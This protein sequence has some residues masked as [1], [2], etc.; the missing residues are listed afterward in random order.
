MLDEEWEKE[1]GG[2]T[3]KNAWSKLMFLKW[4][5]A[6][7]IVPLSSSPQ[8]FDK[9]VKD[10]CLRKCVYILGVIKENYVSTNLLVPVATAGTPEMKAQKG[11]RKRA[12]GKNYK[13]IKRKFTMMWLWEWHYDFLAPIPTRTW[14]RRSEVQAYLYAFKKIYMFICIY[15]FLN[16][17]YRYHSLVFSMQ[18]KAHKIYI[19]WSIMGIGN[20]F[21]HQQPTYE[22]QQ[23]CKVYPRKR[24]E[25]SCGGFNVAHCV[26]N[27]YWTITHQRWIR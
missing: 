9:L 12:R 10:A 4:N 21:W 3:E 22:T 19:M 15:F 23:Q 7:I 20:N 2:C 6:C 16:F 13:A 8:Y 27:S 1:G 11:R 24:I 25:M 26:H 14:T 5:Y 17:V 18:R